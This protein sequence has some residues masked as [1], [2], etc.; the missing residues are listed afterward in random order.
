MNHDSSKK[1]IVHALFV[2]IACLFFVTTVYADEETDTPTS[3]S[4]QSRAN[5]GDIKTQDNENGGSFGAFGS[6]Y[7]E[8]EP[9]D[10]QSPR[11]C[12]DRQSYPSFRSW[13]GIESCLPE[14]N[15]HNIQTKPPVE[16]KSDE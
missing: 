11:G 9:D 13:D 16:Q 7:Q 15:K 1:T 6:E 12:P 14:N 2:S 3:Q 8:I 5:D 4:I 10:E